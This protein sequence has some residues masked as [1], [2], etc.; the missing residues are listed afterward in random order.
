MDLLI[1]IVR[2]SPRSEACDFRAGVPKKTV[3]SQEFKIVVP[4]RKVYTCVYY[5]LWMLWMRREKGGTWDHLQQWSSTGIIPNSFIPQG[6]FDNVWRH[7]WLSWWRGGVQ[8]EGVVLLVSCRLRPWMLINII[9]HRAVP[10]T[11][12]YP[13]ANVYSPKVE[14]PWSVTW[15]ARWK[16]W[17]EYLLQW[18]EWSR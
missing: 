2:C 1:H 3:G 16:L 14:K 18:W 10:M 13:A 12:N 4:T 9:M 15:L 8:G 7:F 5:H 11:K 17:A 6:T